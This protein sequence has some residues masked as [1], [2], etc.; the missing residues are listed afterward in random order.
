MRI[1]F[2]LLLLMFVVG[3]LEEKRRQEGLAAEKLRH[4]TNPRFVGKVEYISLNQ[5]SSERQIGVVPI[6]HVR[7]DDGTWLEIYG[8]A[9][10]KIGYKY[11]IEL[12]TGG[13][14]ESA[15]L[16]DNH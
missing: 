6:T 5:H 8:V 10:L 12:S 11:E 9:P 1:L 13:V 2:A 4:E 14:F 7:F 15:K 3:R 16:L